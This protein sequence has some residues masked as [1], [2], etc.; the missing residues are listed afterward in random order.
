[1][2]DTEKLHRATVALKYL[3]DWNLAQSDW[4]GYLLHIAKWGLGQRKNLPKPEDY[5]QDEGMAVREKKGKKQ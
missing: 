3:R 1:M 4:Q 2:T 5:G